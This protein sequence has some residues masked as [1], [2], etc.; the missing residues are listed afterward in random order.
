MSQSNIVRSKSSPCCIGCI[1]IVVIAVGFSLAMGIYMYRFAKQNISLVTV[2]QKNDP[3]LSTAPEDLFPE[4][5]GD[6]QRS[7]I[8]D[9]LDNVA[10]VGDDNTSGAHVALYTDTEANAVTVTAISTVDAHNEREK[11]IGVLTMGRGKANSA[12][13]GISVRNPFA[14]DVPATIV[15]WSK[16]NWT[17]MVETTSTLASI[18][19]EDFAPG[20]AVNLSDVIEATTAT[21]GFATGLETTDTVEMAPTETQYN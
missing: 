14:G 4:T 15:T 17:F 3:D 18:F 9:V 11:G 8:S 13:T 7:T 20:V 19:V 2:T 12:D 10:V 1:V 5:V 16:P 6:F 21:E